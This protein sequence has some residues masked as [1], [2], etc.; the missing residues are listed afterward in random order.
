MSATLLD[1]SRSSSPSLESYIDASDIE[2]EPSSPVL[3]T[4]E[5]HQPLPSVADKGIQNATEAM[6]DPVSVDSRETDE[7]A[8]LETLGTK[9]ERYVFT[10]EFLV[11][12]VQGRVYRVHSYLFA[13]HS[14][15]WAENLAT[16]GCIKNPIVLDDIS[17]ADMSAFLSMLYPTSMKEHDADTYEEWAAI[18][19]L[20]TTWQFHDIRDFAVNELEY[21]AS[22]VEKL[23]LGRENDVQDWIHPAFVA[24]CMRDGALTIEE[25]R[26]L[27]LEDIRIITSA[28]EALWFKR[29]DTPTRKQVCS[30]VSQYAQCPRNEEEDASESEPEPDAVDLDDES[31][32]ESTSLPQ[33]LSVPATTEELK[34]LA[35]YLYANRIFSD[36][37]AVF[38]ILNTSNIRTFCDALM[39]FGTALSDEGIHVPYFMRA[40]LY[41]G[42][43]QSDF[44]PLG[45]DLLCTLSCILRDNPRSNA[46]ELS[47]I[48][49]E[50]FKAEIAAHV[51]AVTS[52]WDEMDSGHPAYDDFELRLWR[53]TSAQCRLRATFEGLLGD[54]NYLVRNQTAYTERSDNLRAFIAA[55]CEAEVLNKDHT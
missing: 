37:S 42:A 16:A 44:I 6:G 13:A 29:L 32:S 27:S 48:T 11:F 53:A 3:V 30:Y 18:L 49:E 5:D 54:C 21:L 45:V 15:Q 39:N 17:P 34:S 41:R 50:T 8:Y 23:V 31:D 22:P 7:M 19:R 33:T 24:L 12:V 20:A 2:S 46:R 55:L 40:V 10:G 36:Y 26:S 52:V 43:C 4:M 51:A 9:D 38:Q 47:Y 28:R 1:L 35:G 25:F 14:P